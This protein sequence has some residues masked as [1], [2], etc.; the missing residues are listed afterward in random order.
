M[1]VL[2]Q[3]LSELSTQ[4][5]CAHFLGASAIVVDFVMIRQQERNADRL[6][7]EE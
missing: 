2:F 6:C 5:F 7:Q 4:K 3:I 1:V